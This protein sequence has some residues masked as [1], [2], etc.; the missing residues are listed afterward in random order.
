MEILKIILLILAYS[1]GI[2]TL[3]VQI[4]GYGKKIEYRETIILT[5]V[6]LLMI[7][8]FTINSVVK[9]ERPAFLNST[10]VLSVIS[11]VL[12]SL[13]I[14]LNVH[15]ERNI[16]SRRYRNTVAI[17]GGISVSIVAITVMLF[18]DAFSSYLIAS[19][20]LFVS[21]FYSMILVMISKPGLLIA[22]RKEEERRMAVIVM[23]MM[24]ISLAPIFLISRHNLIYVLELTGAW[25][26]ALISIIL[27][28]SKLVSDIKRFAGYQKPFEIND[29]DLSHLKISPREKEVLLLVIRGKTNKDIAE[30]LF[31]SLHTVKSHVSNIYEKLGVKNRM[32]LAALVR[33]GV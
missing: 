33:Q 14:P 29:R 16:K 19:S 2:A 25:V 7:I 30:S 12:L 3:I 15:R 26:F 28:T 10:R 11:I 22:H 4:I 24:L 32:E 5:S 18:N 27:S 9:I 21:V 23:V 20:F 13:A 17:V 6:F 1:M 8:S 31:I